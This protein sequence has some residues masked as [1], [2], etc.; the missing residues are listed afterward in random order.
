VTK[1]IVVELGDIIEALRGWRIRICVGSSEHD[2]RNY[3][4]LINVPETIAESLS[5]EELILL[6]ILSA[7]KK[8]MDYRVAAAAYIYSVKHNLNTAKIYQ[9][10]KHARAYS[11]AIKA[12][13]LCWEAVLYRG[14]L[15]AHAI[16]DSERPALVKVTP[17]KEKLEREKLRVFLEGKRISIKGKTYRV[18]GLVKKLRGKR[19]A[20]WIYLIPKKN[21]AEIQKYAHIEVLML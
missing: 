20:P 5:T 13:H 11:R 6:G 9:L 18:G 14:I 1:A 10:L 17:P 21:I 16:L 12:E 4:A 7:A 19:V 15:Y 3:I 2:F 8:M